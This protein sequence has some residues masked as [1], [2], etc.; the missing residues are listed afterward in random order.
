MEIK[1]LIPN[2]GTMFVFYVGWRAT[3]AISQT[4]LLDGLYKWILD[5]TIDK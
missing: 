1:T 5:I 4:P 2:G 3:P